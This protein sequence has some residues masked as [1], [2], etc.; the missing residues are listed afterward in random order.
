MESTGNILHFIQVFKNKST[1]T[2][3]CIGKNEGGWSAQFVRAWC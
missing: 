3:K 2:W 1:C